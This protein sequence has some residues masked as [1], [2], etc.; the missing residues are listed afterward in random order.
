MPTG[1]RGS[2][3]SSQQAAL[4]YA[5]VARLRAHAA[6]LFARR[7]RTAGRAAAGVRVCATSTGRP[8]RR[9]VQGS[10]AVACPPSP[11]HVAPPPLRLRV[12]RSRGLGSRL[13]RGWT[14][15]LVFHGRITSNKGCKAS[16]SPRAALVAAAHAQSPAPAGGDR[17]GTSCHQPSACPGPSA[18]LSV[19][20]GAYRGRSDM[21]SHNMCMPCK[22]V[23]PMHVRGEPRARHG[24][25]MHRSP[26][27]MGVADAPNRAHP[28]PWGEASPCVRRASAPAGRCGVA[29]RSPR[30]DPPS[31]VGLLAGQPRG[32][33]AVSCLL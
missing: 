29:R 24:C 5:A 32:W 28:R 17:L 7:P 3:P 4:A 14:R 21:R 30:H 18:V 22:Q 20:C 10:G 16:R 8:R 9:R 31:S 11:R 19:Q 26:C 1:R 15:H 33:R 2:P 25:C 27:A 6:G 12:T 23:T 13:S